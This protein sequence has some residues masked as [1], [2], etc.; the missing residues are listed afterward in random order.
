MYYNLTNIHSILRMAPF[1]EQLANAFNQFVGASE[2]TAQPKGARGWSD[3]RSHIAAAGELVRIARLRDVAVPRMRR[4]LEAIR[5]DR[6]CV[7][8]ADTSRSTSG[9]K[10]HELLAE[11][12]GFLVIRNHRWKNASLAD[13]GVDDLLCP[14]RSTP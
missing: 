4:R 13:A 5:E 11:L 6:R 12:R 3:A 1:G 10:P 8:G 2:I 9:T 14:A 7:C